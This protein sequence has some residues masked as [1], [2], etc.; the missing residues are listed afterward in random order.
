MKIIAL[1][2]FKN[3]EWILPVYLKSIGSIA[4]EIIAIDD[5][6][7][8]ESKKLIE[9]FGGIV[10]DNSMK[11]TAGWAEYGIRQKLLDLGRSRYGTHFICLDADEAFT[12]NFI[13]SARGIIESLTPGQ[14]LSMHWL[15]LWKSSDVYRDDDS[16]WSNNYKDFIFCDDGVSN[17]SYA[18]LGVSRT[19]GINEKENN[20]RIDSNVGAVLHYQFLFWER[21]QMKQAWYRCAELLNSSRDSVNEINQMYSITMEDSAIGLKQIPD[22]WLIGIEPPKAG[23]IPWHFYEIKKLFNKHGVEFFEGLQIWH[24]DELRREFFSRTKRY[25][26]TKKQ[27]NYS[28]RVIR[29][30]KNLILKIYKVFCGK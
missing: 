30:I 10:F 17:Y 21:F 23:T 13:F 14:K 4:D 12:S 18:F 26:K 28:L 7:T 20:V 16:V 5:G 24:I 22:S 15:A 11:P 25:P 29:K 9:N 27:Y 6:S 19:P 1:L 8:D 3:E 2:P